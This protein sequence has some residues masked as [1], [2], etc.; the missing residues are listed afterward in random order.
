MQN[1]DILR[2]VE[3]AI[4]P[5]HT[6]TDSLSQEETLSPESAKLILMADRDMMT[7]PLRKRKLYM[8]DSARN[9]ST[10][11]DN[12]MPS[13]AKATSSN[14]LPNATITSKYD[15]ISDIIKDANQKVRRHNSVIQFAK[16][17]T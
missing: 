8:N 4:A 3:A 11:D 13:V 10:Y 2:Q 5:L 9:V 16:A 1:N 7:L 15:D 12:H 6:T 14:L 17:S